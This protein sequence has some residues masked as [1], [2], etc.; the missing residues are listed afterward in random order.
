MRKSALKALAACH[1]IPE[2]RDKI[3]NVIYSKALNSTNNDL[4]EA[5]YEC[6]KK[7]ISGFE[8][9]IKLVTELTKP[10]ISNLAD[11]RNLT[12]NIIARLCFLAELFPKVFNEKLCEQLLQLLKKWLEISII[13]PSHPPQK[14]IEML[15]KLILTT[16][17][18][19]L[20]EPGSILREPLIG[21]LIKYPSE[22]VE[23]FT[24]DITAKDPQNGR[25]I[26]FIMKHQGASSKNQPQIT[27]KE[28]ADIQLVCIRMVWVMVKHDREW[29][30]DQ[31]PSVDALKRVWNQDAYHDKIPKGDTLHQN[32][33]I[34]L[35]FQLLRALVG[36]YIADF[37]FLKDFLENEVCQVYSTNGNARPSSSLSDCGT[38][39]ISIRGEGDS[40]IGSPPS[41]DQDN[42]E[43][44][45]STF[46]N[47]IIDTGIAFWHFGHSPD[48]LAPILA[49]FWWTGEPLT[50]TTPATRARQQAKTTMT[51]ACLVLLSKNCVDPATRYHGH[52]LLS[53][54][55]CQVRHPTSGSCSRRSLLKM[56]TPD[57]SWSIFCNLVVKHFKVY[58]PVRHHLIQHIVS[59]IQRLGFTATATIEQ[60]KLAVDLCEIV[61]NWE[62]HRVK[63]ESE[64]N[65][66]SFQFSHFLLSIL[67]KDQVLTAFKPLQKAIST[68]MNCP[69]AKVSEPC[70]A[71]CPRLM[72]LF[73]TEP[74]S[75]NVA[76]QT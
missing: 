34:L 33:E 40:L 59:S 46:I 19:L 53:H 68:C 54:I 49:A 18:N 26:E 58:Y 29:I 57:P 12:Q 38:W 36:R 37:Q 60:K 76:L 66:D 75:S 4:V 3:F 69:N 13:P 30:K 50:F 23:Y 22:T 61:I 63:E 43:N 28:R 45:V 35:L 73:P 31:N 17:R 67:R 10:I 70:I 25:F 48:P 9:D 51:Y 56:D 65:A 44:V 71:S 27:P 16:E 39:P 5:G 24:N 52:L 8:V 2:C 14:I 15:C 41:P 47:S 74:T 32:T 21:Y 42:P 11:Y 62:K 72:N 1:Y 64:A 20:I 7:F 55:N 6:M